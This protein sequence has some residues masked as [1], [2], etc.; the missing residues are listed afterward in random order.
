MGA[1]M[2]FRITF[3][4]KKDAKDFMKK[5]EPIVLV[6]DFADSLGFAA[7]KLSWKPNT[8]I[9]FMGFMGYAEPEEI[10]KMLKGRI[11]YFDWI[12]INDLNARWKKD[13]YNG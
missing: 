2:I 3:K 1:F 12:S 4:E 10:K 7:W 6:D 5:F 8:L 11:R 13:K 9:C